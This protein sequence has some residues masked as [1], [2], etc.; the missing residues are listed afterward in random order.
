MRVVPF[1]KQNLC[2]VA[3]VGMIA[4]VLSV[5]V[6]VRASG[7]RPF[8]EQAILQQID[9]EDAA[10]CETFGFAARTPR[11]TDCMLALTDLRQRHVDLLRSYSWL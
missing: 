11:S 5:G 2:L 1:V 8:G 7:I 3:I 10:L 9:H 6:A 4:A